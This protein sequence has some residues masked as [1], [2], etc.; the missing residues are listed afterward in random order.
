MTIKNVIQAK[1]FITKDQSKKK[2]SL[3]NKN[4]NNF[5]L[6]KFVCMYRIKLLKSREKVTSKIYQLWIWAKFEFNFYKIL[7]CN[8]EKL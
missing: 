8:L 1:N 5:I 3:I 6:N 4:K 2:S 7:V